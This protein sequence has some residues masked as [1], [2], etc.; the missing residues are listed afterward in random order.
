MKFPIKLTDRGEVGLCILEDLA[1]RILFPSS[2]IK[3]NRRQDFHQRDPKQ[4]NKSDGLPPPS[5][6]FPK[7]SRNLV[8]Y[9]SN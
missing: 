7:F 6:K 3:V 4:T 9:L 8:F 2:F 1:T 5:G